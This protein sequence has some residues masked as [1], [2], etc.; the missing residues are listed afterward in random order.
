MTIYLMAFGTGYTNGGES[1][2][3]VLKRAHK[4]RFHVLSAKHLDRFVDEF[5]RHH[6]I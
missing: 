6:N 5:A 1:F 4:G 2:W 3:A